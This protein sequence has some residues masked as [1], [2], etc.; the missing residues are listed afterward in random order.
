MKKAV[1]LGISGGI[2][3]YK[4]VDLIKI[5]QFNDINVDVIL[6]SGGGEIISKNELISKTGIKP[7]VNLFE[8]KVN[9][10]EILKSRKVEHIDLAR[11]SDLIVIAPATANLIA[12]LAQGIADDYLTTTV[13]AATCP[14]IICPS[15]NVHMWENPATQKNVEILRARGFHVIN[16][17]SGML[18][19]G[20]E[21][22]GR[23]ADIN[24]IA[25]EI[26]NLL[27]KKDLLKGK[28]IIVTSGGTTE[29]IDDVRFIANRSSGKMGAAI[30][31]QAFLNGAN[32]IIVRSK[33]SVKP[34]FNIKEK[35]F[36]TAEEL[37]K[38]LKE[39]VIN[40]NVVIHSAAVSDFKPENV[41]KGKIS[42]DLKINLKLIP[43]K[44]ILS[45]IK[46]I[47]PK[48][49]LVGFKALSG[50]L[51][52]ELIENAK[53]TLKKSNADFVVANDVSKKDRG[54]EVDD[55]E[56]WIIDKKEKVL[57]IPLISKT[58]VAQKIIEEIIKSL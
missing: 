8:K 36:E 29:P 51:E 46:Q 9:R 16:P 43:Q 5:L 1:L 45:E 44:K 4:A 2:A 49:I 17:D 56:V 15:M 12:K 31:E 37:D 13:L 27:N 32:V 28:K 11:K 39:E 55:N 21:G 34:R 47:N 50:V 52:K 57:Y 54:F 24:F 40:A 19:C 7:Y 26:F 20:Y 10:E 6:T 42:S 58:I 38:I 14:I 23:L 22:M 41:F 48:I 30:A 25:D 18:A 3:A 53:Q 35:I 33:N